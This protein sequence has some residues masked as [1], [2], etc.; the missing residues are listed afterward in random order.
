MAVTVDAWCLTAVAWYSVLLALPAN[1][2]NGIGRDIPLDRVSLFFPSFPPVTT[3]VATD[4]KP[5]G[6][7]AFSVA[8]LTALRA[9]ADMPGLEVVAEPA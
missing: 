4:D 7:I 9:R 2:P 8:D 1:P 5:L 3:F 6:H